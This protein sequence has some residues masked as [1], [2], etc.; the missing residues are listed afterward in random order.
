M[1]VLDKGMIYSLEWDVRDFILL[2]RTV[3]NL[4]LII[5]SKNGQKIETDISPNKTCRW[6]NRH[7]NRCSSSLNYSRNAN[8]NYNEVLPHTSQNGHH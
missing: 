1:D 2:F 7:M 3:F 6:P 8:Q 4:K 5:Q